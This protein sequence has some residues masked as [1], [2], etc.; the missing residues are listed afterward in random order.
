MINLNYELILRYIY[1]NESSLEQILRGLRQ[2]HIDSKLNT[3]R[4]IV[5]LCNVSKQLLIESRQAFFA[6]LIQPEV[7]GL[8]MDIMLYKEASKAGE[9]KTSEPQRLQHIE[10]EGEFHDEYGVGK[11]GLL[12]T[13][14]AEILTGCFQILPSKVIASYATP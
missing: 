4:F 9:A 3:V 8:L 6:R 11:L 10:G 12:K 1:E 14:V 5:D 7:I 2:D 13:H